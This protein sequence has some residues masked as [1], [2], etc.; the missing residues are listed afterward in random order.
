M[1]SAGK[2]KK[3]R[4]LNRAVEPYVKITFLNHLVKLFHEKQELN[5]VSNALFSQTF[6]N[7]GLCHL[8]A[9]L[10]VLLH[11]LNSNYKRGLSRRYFP[12][13]E[14]NLQ[15]SAL[16]QY[17]S[18]SCWV[19]VYFL[20]ACCTLLQIL[21]KSSLVSEVAALCIHQQSLSTQQSIFETCE[22]LHSFYKVHALTHR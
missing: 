22:Q 4:N 6:S 15:Q 12:F 1:V 10:L 13:A 11:S 21:L 19:K 8:I 16:L 17:R 18:C 3:Y 14:R 2:N 9:L 7:A 20:L 5:V